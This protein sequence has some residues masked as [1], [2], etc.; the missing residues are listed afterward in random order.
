M[1]RREFFEKSCIAG[2]GSLLP[3][4]P[5]EAG[6]EPGC[7]VAAS[8][9][10]SGEYDE[11]FVAMN[12]TDRNPGTQQE[13]FATVARAKEVVRE[14]RKQSRKA[15]VVWVRN[16]TYYLSE[17]LVFE[18]A[19]SGTEKPITYAAYTGEQVTLSGGRKLTCRWNP[20]KDGIMRCELPEVRAGRCDF[21]Q[22]FINGKRQIRA[23]YPNFD[24]Q[25]PLVGGTG[26]IDVA[27]EA[28]NWPAKGFPYN[29]GTFTKKRWAKPQE[30]VVHIFHKHYYGSLQWNVES[31]DWESHV[32]NLGWGGFQ[33]NGSHTEN[34]SSLLGPASRY[35]IENVFEELDAPGEWYLDNE[36]GLLYYLPAED[37]DLASAVVE[38][39]ILDRV[40]EFRGSQRNPVRQ[41]TFSGFRIAHT[42]STFLAQYEAPSRGDWT[43][44]RGGAVFLEGAEDCSIQN[45]F[46]DAVGGNGVF[47]NDY[48]RRI[49]LYG[50][51]FTGAGDSAVCLVGTA[52]LVQGSQWPFPA[53]NTIS[54]NLIHDCGAFGKQ[55]AGVFISI[56]EKN[57]VSH[58]LIYNM[59]RAGICINDGWGGG[60]I[61]EFNKIYDTVLETKD[62]G[63][64]N[65]WGR[66]EYWCAQQSHGSVSHGAGNVRQMTK[67]P[68]LIRNNYF[69]DNHEWGI[70]LDDGSSNT[71]VYNN[72]CVGIS[73]KLREGDYRLVENNTFVHPAN[74]P[75]L[76][77]GYE[78]NHDRFVRNIIVTSTKFD[79][80]ALDI[81]FQKGKAKGDV[82]QVIF[83]PLK[84]PVLQEIDYNVFFNDVGEFYATVTPRGSKRGIRYTLDQW[85]KL[86]FDQHSVYADPIFVDPDK[87]DYHVKP[88]S[89]AIKLGF[90]NF[91]VE[92]V[93]LLPDFP[94]QWRV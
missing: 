10:P 86:G 77:V 90:K 40:I 16:G 65:S 15:I 61:L 78:Y 91:D 44:H 73:I 68:I 37:I 50:N 29:P 85:R 89:P 48:S 19:D 56:S 76:H 46:F 57:T 26:Y 43:L 38:V 92:K 34:I 33:I 6:N 39:P 41:I 1:N 64:F 22:L 24:H 49:R 12:G 2:V 67:W 35:F 81:N 31:V 23:R 9:V 13:P 80:P 63:P 25:N 69:Q 84:G 27:N 83:P 53:E 58:N 59:P 71:H 82:Y 51:R 87:G 3:S 11:L 93:G 45:C 60:H 17:P 8:N 75:G 18:P 36:E 7:C 32:V 52:S 42:A 4:V 5:V 54:N 74:P 62:H 79:R 30:A 47:I 94:E 28:K 14:L 20:Y 88:E 21:S 66:G 70:D 72:L 55:V